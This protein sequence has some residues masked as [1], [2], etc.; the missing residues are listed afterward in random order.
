MA[1]G[2]TEAV[3]RCRALFYLGKRGEGEGAG[4]A[5]YGPGQAQQFANRQD[6][7]R[8]GS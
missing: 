3:V 2:A 1:V 5:T 4:V 7:A 6:G 8:P